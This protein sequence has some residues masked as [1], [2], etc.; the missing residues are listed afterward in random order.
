[1]ATMKPL[2]AGLVLL[3]AAAA[4]ASPVGSGSEP[5]T[6][7][8]IPRAS[9]PSGACAPLFTGPPD[10]GPNLVPGITV[11]AIDKRHTEITNATNRTYYYRVSAWHSDLLACGF[12]VTESE[13][14]RGP[15]A[16]GETVEVGEGSAP[17]L[18]IAVGIWD[19]MCGEACSSPPIGWMFVP[20]S[21]IEPVP[22]ST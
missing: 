6:G 5:P 15:I 19:Q 3:L 14:Q 10:A 4:C 13:F 20:V 8:P 21:S 22:E 11:R 2:A 17:R 9:D 1:M 18:P 7:S 12:G 16:S